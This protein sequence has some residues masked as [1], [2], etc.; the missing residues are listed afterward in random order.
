MPRTMWI[1][2]LYETDI[3]SGARFTQSLMTGQA[4]SET[5]LVQMTLMLTIIRLDLAPVVMDQGEGSNVIDL[6]VGV[7]EQGAVAA[8]E[9]PD[10]SVAGDTPPEVGFT[11][12]GGASGGRRRTVQ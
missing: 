6:G 4:T 11:A 1:D 7:G 10:P 8:G 5:R 9:V 12:D 3:A 2:T